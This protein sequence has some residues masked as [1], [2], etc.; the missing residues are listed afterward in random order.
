MASVTLGN[1]SPTALITDTE[2]GEKTRYRYTNIGQTSTFASSP[3]PDLFS[4]MRDIINVWKHESDK[5]P[6]WVEADDEALASALRQHFGCGAR[7]EDWEHVITGPPAMEPV[8]ADV[9]VAPEAPAAPVVDAEP[10]P[11]P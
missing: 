2:T 11:I 1:V 7:P 6:A 10:A 5:P 8:T 3:E 4:Q 9:P